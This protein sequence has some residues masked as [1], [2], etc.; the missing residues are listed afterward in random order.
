MASASVSMAQC[1]R[2]RRPVRGR[3]AIREGR[4]PTVLFVVKA[5]IAAEREQEFK[6]EYAAHFGGARERARFAYTQ[7]RP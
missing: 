2:F 5:T 3:L 1:G 6:A 4:M 7:V